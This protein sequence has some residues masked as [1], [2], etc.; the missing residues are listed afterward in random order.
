MRAGLE[1]IVAEYDASK[2]NDNG[3]FEQAFVRVMD[4]SED[5]RVKV[6]EA[7]RA[8]PNDPAK[9]GKNPKPPPQPKPGKAPKPPTPNEDDVKSEE[10]LSGDDV[11]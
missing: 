4:G 1:D 5:T 8:P 10:A 3:V 6:A 2:L 7:V 11:E 9:K